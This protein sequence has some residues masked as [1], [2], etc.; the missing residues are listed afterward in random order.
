MKNLFYLICLI[1]FAQLQAQRN[2]TNVEV[3]N[4][5]P[6]IHGVASGDPLS[7]RVILWTRVTDSGAQPI[8]VTYI[9]ATDTGMTNVI[10]QGSLTTDAS[11]D[12]TV[13]VDAGGLQPNTVYY[14]EFTALGQRS[15]RGRT[16][17]LPTGNVDSMRL[18]LVSCAHYE[19]GFFNA[20]EVIRNRNDVDFVVHLGD[21]IYEYETGGLGN[22]VGNRIFNPDYE[23]TVLNDYRLRYSFYKTDAQL[24]M[25]HQQYPF[26]FV[27]DDHEFA[28]DAWMGGA[29]NHT[30]GTE[31]LWVNRKAD[32]IK[33]WKEW[34]PI[35]E[36]DVSDPIRIYR[37]F[38]FGNLFDLIMTDTRMYG[39]EQQVGVTSSTAN[40]TNR[41]LYGTNQRTWLYNE[42][43]NSQ[44]KWRLLGNQIMMA[45]LKLF[46]I[47][48]NNDSWDNYTVERTNMWN[49]M[50]NKSNCVVLTGDFHTAWA[51]DLPASGYVSSTG[52][53]SAGVEFVV[54]SVTTTNFNLP[55]VES[56][57]LLSNN[58][59]KWAKFTGHG[60]AIIDIRKTQVQCDY[61]EMQTVDNQSVGQVHRSSWKTLDGTNHLVQG[62]ESSRPTGNPTL[63]PPNPR[64]NPTGLIELPKEVTITSLF[65]N[66]AETNVYFQLVA[67]KN[68]AIKAIITD[69]NGKEVTQINLG[70]LNKGLHLGNI[71]ISAL[72]SGIYNL[73]LTNNSQTITTRKFIVK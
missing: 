71:D 60:Y 15:I 19:N 45:P 39:R 6:F 58:H 10:T 47:P 29:Q 20:Y 64:T 61:Y 27:W 49:V 18:A 59:I 37:T 5:S 8:P 12:Y 3:R 62:T 26:I 54:T 9:V 1:S 17:T 4:A 43:N 70:K 31:G 72:P 32:A 68:I 55:S 35:R 51:N 50:R 52:G 44:A 30:E 33:A 22:T 24:Q 14:Y 41:S 57:A 2:Y 42:V 67:N 48:V 23:I 56:V 69:L 53:N 13:K 28:N 65:P 46:G 63:A 25:I 73:I 7:D 38:N 66:P 21:Y 16:R 40:A 36:P 11:V 34:M